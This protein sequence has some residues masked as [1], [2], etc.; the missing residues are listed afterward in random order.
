MDMAPFIAKM[1]IKAANVSEE[2]GQ[3][4]YRAYF[5]NTAIYAMYQADVNTILETEGYGT[6]IVTA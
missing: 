4:K 5:V 1:I 6:C 3:A 2:A